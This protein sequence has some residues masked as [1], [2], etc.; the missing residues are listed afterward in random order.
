MWSEIDTLTF[1][2]TD[3][4]RLSEFWA[5]TV[6]FKVV[7]TWDEGGNTGV[8]MAGQGDMSL[9]LIFIRVP[10]AK[11]VKNR[12]HLDL[13]P[14]RTR[15][16]EVERLRGLG[17]TVVEGFGARYILR[18]E[19]QMGVLELLYFVDASDDLGEP[20]ETVQRFVVKLPAEGG[21]A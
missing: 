11:A 5:Q 18:R 19:G 8:L 2:C 12:L 7:D 20:F 4:V 10:E 21:D 15:D 17:A 3:P 6:G 14:P 1:D 16:E 9:R 13:T